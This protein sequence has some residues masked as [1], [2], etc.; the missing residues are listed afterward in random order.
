MFKQTRVSKPASLM[1]FAILAPLGVAQADSAGFTT[2]YNFTGGS[3]GA[4]PLDRLVIGKSGSLFGTTQYGGPSN[5]GTVFELKRPASPGG[6]WTETVLYG[7]PPAY[8]PSDGLAVGKNG[9]LY[10]TTYYGGASG[11]GAVFELAPPSSAGGTWTESTI[12]S[13][14]APNGD[15]QNPRAGVVIG[16]GGV[17]YGATQYGGISSNCTYYGCGA[18]FALTPP[19]SPGGA[20]TESTI[21]TFMGGN[22]GAL[23]LRSLVIGDNGSLYGSTYSGGPSPVCQSFLGG[24]GTV[25]ELTPPSSPAVPWTE[26]VLYSFTGGADGGFP[27]AVLYVNGVLYGMTPF[28]GDLRACGGY[29]CGTVFKLTPPAS[30][31]SA[32]TETV[33]Y[34]FKGVPDGLY[35]SSW[36]GLIAGKNGALYGTTADGGT[37]ADCPEDP[38]CGTVFELTPGRWNAGWTE[39]ALHS[40]AAG[41][42]FRPYA[43]LAIGKNGTLYGTTTFGG[44]ST[45]CLGGCGT[46]FEV[47]P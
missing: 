7:F 43:G 11:V 19:A 8:F 23:V 9:E 18:V 28:G 40:F 4:Y 27:S 34:G 12:Y 38:G 13:F 10:G 16:K 35:P 33:L 21:Y 6:A 1:A 25:F 47:R 26:T 15:P 5:G 45:A 20:W 17:L 41:E 14:T 39:R 30:T 3:D 36:A 42:G 29:G 31:G 32:W 2:L 44:T 37:S 22:D 24:C 46:V